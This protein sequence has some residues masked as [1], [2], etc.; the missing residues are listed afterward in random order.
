[1]H[2]LHKRGRNSRMNSKFVAALLVGTAM[3]F[4][5]PAYAQDAVA[6]PQQDMEPTQPDESD[7]TA[8]ATIA[9]APGVEHAQAKIE[10]LQAQVEALQTAIDQI[11]T[12]LVKATPTWK[13][14]PQYDEKESGFSFKP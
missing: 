1:M 5:A 10:L 14:A 7:A 2:L 9:N 4:S 12:S 6:E 8:D 3:S 13:G 11:K